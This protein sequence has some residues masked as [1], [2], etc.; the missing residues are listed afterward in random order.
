MFYCTLRK[1]GKRQFP[2]L[3]KGTEYD[4]A[5][6]GYIKDADSLFRKKD[7]LHTLIARINFLRH[8]QRPVEN[9]TVYLTE[10]CLIAMVCN[11]LNED[12]IL[13]TKLKY[14]CNDY[15]AQAKMFSDHPEA[16]PDFGVILRILHAEESGETGVFLFSKPFFLLPE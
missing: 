9:V 1:E 15:K 10:L 11:W 7:Q 4:C 12:D 3:P 2:S 16:H 8:E 13:E 5:Y 14:G 6:E